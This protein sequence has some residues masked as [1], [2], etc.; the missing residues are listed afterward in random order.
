MKIRVVA[1]NRGDLI[2]ACYILKQSSVPRM[3]LTYGQAL[4]VIWREDY[5][6]AQV[7]LLDGESFFFES[8]VEYKS[9]HTARFC[10][11]RKPLDSHALIAIR[12]KNL[13]RFAREVGYR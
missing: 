9:Y 2:T 5:M 10:I 12:G 4:R 6:W 8:C 7:E 13:E 1:K 11:E 3:E